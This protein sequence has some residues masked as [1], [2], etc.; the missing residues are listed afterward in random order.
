MHQPPRGNDGSASSHHPD[1][2]D[3]PRTAQ[4]GVFYSFTSLASLDTP[5]TAQRFEIRAHITLRVQEMLQTEGRN[6]KHK[7]RA[8][9]VMKVKPN[10]RSHDDKSQRQVT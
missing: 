1:I 2:D 10:D 9:W 6:P 4:H 7:T 3:F 5:V 8:F